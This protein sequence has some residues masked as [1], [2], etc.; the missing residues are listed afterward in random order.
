MRGEGAEDNFR[1]ISDNYFTQLAAI[2]SKMIHHSVVV[3]IRSQDQ[4][5]N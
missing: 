2:M 3:S 5:V 4:R 1:P